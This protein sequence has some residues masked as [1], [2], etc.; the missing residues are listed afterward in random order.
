[1]IMLIMPKPRSCSPWL[2]CDGVKVT[3]QWTGH[4]EGKLHV[5]CNHSGYRNACIPTCSPCL[6][7]AGQHV[8]SFLLQPFPSHSSHQNWAPCALSTEKRKTVKNGSGILK[9]SL[10]AACCHCCLLF[11]HTAKARVTA[12]PMLLKEIGK[13]LSLCQVKSV[14]SE[15]QK[16]HSYKYRGSFL[17]SCSYC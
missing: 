6:A 11:R 10:G 16:Y 13:N 5:L 4:A 7:G 2:C 17:E 9:P 1:M 14:F 12:F 3:Q 15:V 8:G